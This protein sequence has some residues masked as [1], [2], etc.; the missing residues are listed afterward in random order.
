MDRSST[1]MRKRLDQPAWPQPKPGT[2]AGARRARRRSHSRQREARPRRRECRVPGRGRRWRRLRHLSQRVRRPVA[3]GGSVPCTPFGRYAG[4]ERRVCRRCAQNR[5]PRH[6]RGT[7]RVVGSPDFVEG[8]RRRLWHLARK[9]VSP[10]RVEGSAHR[11]ARRALP[12]RPRRDRRRGGRRAP[13]RRRAHRRADRIARDRDR[14]VRGTAPGRIAAHALR[15]TVG[16]RQR[17]GARGAAVAARDREGD[18]RHVRR[19]PGARLP[20]F[21]DRPRDDGRSA[22]PSAP[23]CEPGCVQRRQGRRR[24]PR[25]ALSCIARRHRGRSAEQRRVGPLGCLRRGVSHDRVVGERRRRG[26]RATAHAAIRGP[27]GVRSARLRGDDGPRHRVGF[28][29]EYGHRVP[30][31]RIEGRVARVD[32]AVVHGHRAALGGAR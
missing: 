26:R 7:V 27:R 3:H 15:A 28:G 25:A 17:S 24:G 11:R 4:S 14:G 9:S 10:L 8:D 22:V 6:R 21:G 30:V 32:H 20:P 5:D 16:R 13:R 2:H 12:S 23:A 19:R 29:P 1:V 31:D 18:A